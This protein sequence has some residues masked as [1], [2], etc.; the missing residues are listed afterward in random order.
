MLKLLVR[1]AS[2]GSMQI[3][4]MKRAVKIV[5]R[6]D[7]VMIAMKSIASHAQRDDMGLKRG[8]RRETRGAPTNVVQVL[9][10]TPRDK[11]ALMMPAS[12]AC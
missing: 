1:N 2:L 11:P 5:K 10:A 7:T 3:Q 6:V 9:T 8:R 4:K 12:N